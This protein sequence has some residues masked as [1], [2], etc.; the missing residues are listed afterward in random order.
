[1]LV[2]S[3]CEGEEKFGS[4]QIDVK[5]FLTPLRTEQEPMPKNQEVRVGAEP[6]FH[7]VAESLKQWPPWRERRWSFLSLGDAVS[8][9]MVLVN[10]FVNRVLFTFDPSSYNL[11]LIDC[12][13]S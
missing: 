3:S 5:P 12:S 11:L 7:V 6:A 9:G 2:S 8:E 1:M 10:S 4:R 13:F